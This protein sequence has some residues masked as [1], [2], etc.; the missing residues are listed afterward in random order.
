MNSLQTLSASKNNN[1]YNVQRD[2]W[3]S[4]VQLSTGRS[5]LMR[6]MLFV[7]TETAQSHTW[8]I[9]IQ[10]TTYFILIQWSIWPYESHWTEICCIPYENASL[11][12]LHNLCII[13]GCSHYLQTVYLKKKPGLI[14]LNFFKLLE[15]L[16]S[17]ES[18]YFCFNNLWEI[19]QLQY[20]PFPK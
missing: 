6:C 11:M 19:L 9:F 18:S 3:A 14:F 16:V 4:N 15:I 13:F 8:G 7:N 10:D 12:G 1:T 2:Q 5:R 20:D 17:K